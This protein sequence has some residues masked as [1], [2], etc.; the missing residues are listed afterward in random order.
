ML[1]LKIRIKKSLLMMNPIGVKA[2]SM[3]LRRMISKT[4]GLIEILRLFV[5]VVWRELFI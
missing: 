3:N 1:W 5:K 2:A 4:I